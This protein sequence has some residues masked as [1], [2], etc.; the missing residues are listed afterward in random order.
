MESL[1][2]LRWPG[3]TTFGA[4]FGRSASQT[5]QISCEKSLTNV[6]IYIMIK[7]D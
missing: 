1:V 5:L 2:T 7:S 3:N 4:V 6:L